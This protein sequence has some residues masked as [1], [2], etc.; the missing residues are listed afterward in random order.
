M[1]LKS[2]VTFY[3]LQDISDE[4]LKKLRDMLNSGY[5]QEALD[6]FTGEYI[7]APTENYQDEIRGYLEDADDDVYSIK[8]KNHILRNTALLTIGLSSLLISNFKRFVKEAYSENVFDMAGMTNPDA[9][10]V[11]LDEVINNFEQ[12]VTNSLAQT[13]TF[14]SG[15]IQTLQKEMILHNLKTKKLKLDGDALSEEKKAFNRLLKEKYPEIYK[16]IQEGNI[17]A[18]H[19]FDGQEESVRHYKLSKYI[20]GALRDTILNVDREAVLGSAL[21]A[22]EKVV[23]FYQSDQRQVQKDRPVCQEILHKL[24]LGRPLLALDDQSARVLGI[25]SIAEAED[26]TALSWNCRHAFRRLSKEFLNEIDK[27]IGE[28]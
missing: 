7:T 18:I 23:E 15:S 21:V 12:T 10:K 25:M 19:K 20:D 14:I 13:S 27:L 17:L 22:G 5:V 26:Q 11:I 8:E 4:D 1:D 28:K 6:M 16:A 24:T 3:R 2:P 9:K